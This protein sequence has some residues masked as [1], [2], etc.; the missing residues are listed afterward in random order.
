M[1]GERSLFRRADFDLIR[2]LLDRVISERPWREEGPKKANQYSRA[3][4]S[5]PRSS[6]S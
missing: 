1:R 3:I 4:F 5:K 6:A 2:E